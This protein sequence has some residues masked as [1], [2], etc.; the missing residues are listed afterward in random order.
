MKPLSNIGQHRICYPNPYLSSADPVFMPEPNSA[1]TM[2]AII[3]APNVA[4]LEVKHD[5]HLSWD[6]VIQ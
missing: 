6:I 2:P 4:D 3:L 1:V 5:F